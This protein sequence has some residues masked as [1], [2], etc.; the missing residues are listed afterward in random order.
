MTNFTDDFEWLLRAEYRA[1]GADA[2]HKTSFDELL[3]GAL[4]AALRRKWQ[5][6][7]AVCFSDNFYCP[8][9][10]RP[11]L[12]ALVVAI[13]KGED[14]SD[15]ESNRLSDDALFED[16]LWL[17]WGISHFHLGLRVAPG[18]P[19]GRTGPLAFA[20]LGTEKAY[21]LAVAKHDFENFDLLLTMHNSFPELFRYAEI[22]GARP[23]A[24]LQEQQIRW[25]RKH[26]INTTYS[27]PNGSLFMSPGGGLMSGPKSGGMHERR[28][29]DAVYRQLESLQFEAEN[30]IGP[31][32][33][34]FP[35]TCQ[36]KSL[37]YEREE[38]RLHAYCPGA[39]YV[40]KFHEAT[41][42]LLVAILR[43]AAGDKS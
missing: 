20:V 9:E 26:R 29:A 40:V 12:D 8:E 13:T 38:R 2:V 21:V 23:A 35:G 6:P 28:C 11:G 4:R 1:S 19:V 25:Y 30:L 27:G 14:L 32:C 36:S 18:Q 34:R 43:A 22:K 17:D 3:R 15:W 7:R 39:A 37:L 41:T 5:R 42:Q 16:K 24:P 10:L 31:R 33:D